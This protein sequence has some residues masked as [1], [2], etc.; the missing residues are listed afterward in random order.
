M[1]SARITLVAKA[2]YAS[3]L[4]RGFF[5]GH[6]LNTFDID[7]YTSQQKNQYK[8]FFKYIF[9]L[10]PKQLFIIIYVNVI[11]QT[12]TSCSVTEK[13][14]KVNLPSHDRIRHLNY[15]R[16]LT[17]LSTKVNNLP[18]WKFAFYQE[19]RCHGS[20]KMTVSERGYGSSWIDSVNRPL[21][22]TLMCLK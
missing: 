19:R 22:T 2:A 11:W 14:R 1:V 10:N 6:T 20:V 12:I 16:S 18:F 3:G 15:M 5:K 17:V 7:I 21:Q 8:D 13:F 9:M 4:G